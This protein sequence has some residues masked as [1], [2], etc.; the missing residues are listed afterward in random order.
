MELKTA[1]DIARRSRFTTAIKNAKESRSLENLCILASSLN[2]LTDSERREASRNI[3]QS[4]GIPK[5]S[6]VIWGIVNDPMALAV[7]AGSII[8]ARSEDE[9][10]VLSSRGGE[11]TVSCAV[12]WPQNHTPKRQYYHYR[13]KELKNS[14]MQAHLAEIKSR[15]I[16]R[17]LLDV[18]ALKT[19]TKP[20]KT[21]KDK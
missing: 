20:P 11:W 19:K 4:F 17:D 3:V 8:W 10:S 9:A 14:Y 6:S 5:A 18:D 21:G 7:K 1:F 16:S 2:A 12:A 15:A 13:E